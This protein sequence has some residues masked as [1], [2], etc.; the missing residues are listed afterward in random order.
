MNHNGASA[1]TASTS[2]SD[3]GTRATEPRDGV[4]HPMIAVVRGRRTDLG[5][6]QMTASRTC[7]NWAA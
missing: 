2:P 1:A 6:V 5:L 3:T 7:V 4:E